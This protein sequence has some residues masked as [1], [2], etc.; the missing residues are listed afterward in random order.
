LKS[1]DIDHTIRKH[2]PKLQ[3][4]GVLTVRPGYEIAA[5]WLTDK[6]VI[7]ATVDPTKRLADLSSSERLPDKLGKYPVDVREASP[8]QRLRTYDPAAANVAE[9][10]GRPEE[11]DPIHFGSIFSDDLR[12]RTIP[13]SK[14]QSATKT[15]SKK[16]AA[17]KTPTKRASKKASSAK[18]KPEDKP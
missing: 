8:Y 4:S 9:T 18:D 13:A 16:T 17:K 14:V 5:D 7:V 12:N 11:Q 2:L 15:A 3:K 6:Q 10:Y 1:R